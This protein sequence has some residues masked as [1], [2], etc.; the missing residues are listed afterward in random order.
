[1][2][3]RCY[4]DHNED[5]R[6]KGSCDYCKGTVPDPPQPKPDPVPWQDENWINEQ[7]G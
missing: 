1:M 4:S 2:T 6:T 3:A 5:I 7:E